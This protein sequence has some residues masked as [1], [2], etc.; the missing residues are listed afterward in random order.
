MAPHGF[1]E[2]CNITVLGTTVLCYADA[3]RFLRPWIMANERKSFFATF[4]KDLGL[5]IFSERIGGNLRARRMFE[6]TGKVLM[7]V[8]RDACIISL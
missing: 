1:E 3:A 5:N 4:E 7:E 8:M 6:G 2:V